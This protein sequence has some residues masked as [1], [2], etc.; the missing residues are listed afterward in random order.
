MQQTC[1]FHW[2]ATS[3]SKTSPGPGSVRRLVKFRPVATLLF[4][5][6]LEL[7]KETCTKAVDNRFWQSTY[8]K[9]VHNLQ[10]TCRSQAV[11][12]HANAPGYRFVVRSLL[13][14]VDRLGATCSLWAVHLITA[15]KLLHVLAW[16]KFVII[17]DQSCWLHF[18]PITKV[19]QW[20]KRILMTFCDKGAQPSYHMFGG[21][22]AK[23]RP[24]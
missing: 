16:C 4:A 23:L 11:A 13:Q 2:V 20:Y 6:L 21:L 5:D 9:S 22:A 3:L 8:N 10:Q 14:D 17:L 1:R 18:F 19:S 15:T 12:S 7:V 24:V